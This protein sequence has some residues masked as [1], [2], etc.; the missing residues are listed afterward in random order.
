MW[1]VGQHA[2]SMQTTGSMSRVRFHL[3]AADVR[4]A[5]CVPCSFLELWSRNAMR[6][7]VL[8]LLVRLR[9]RS[10]L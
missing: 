6:E 3:C 10:S 2:N 9:V 8:L 7:R 1:G 4:A 5:G